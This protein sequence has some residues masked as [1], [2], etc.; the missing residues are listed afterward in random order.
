MKIRKILLVL[1]LLWFGLCLNPVYPAGFSDPIVEQMT[2]LFFEKYSSQHD[3]KHDEILRGL[4]L[5]PSD[6]LEEYEDDDEMG[7]FYI[8]MALRKKQPVWMPFLYPSLVTAYQLKNGSE[9]EMTDWELDDIFD[10]FIE[11]TNNFREAVSYLDCY[12]ELDEKKKTFITSLLFCELDF[13]KDF[14]PGEGRHFFK[15]KFKAYL[16]FVELYPDHLRYENFK[17]F[18]D[19]IPNEMV[20]PWAECWDDLEKS[21]PE[22]MCCMGLCDDPAQWSVVAGGQAQEEEHPALKKIRSRR[23]K[24]VKVFAGR[25]DNRYWLTTKTLAPGET[26]DDHIEEPCLE[27]LDQATGAHLKTR[28]VSL[29]DCGVFTTD[30]LP[31]LKFGRIPEGKELLEGIT[32]FRVVVHL[33]VMPATG[34]FANIVLKPG[35]C[36][37]EG[38][39]TIQ[40]GFSGFHYPGFNLHCADSSSGK[41][42][43]PFIYDPVCQYPNLLLYHGQGTVPYGFD[44]VSGRHQPGGF[45][46]VSVIRQVNEKEGNQGDN[47]CE[48][49]LTI[50]RLYISEVDIAQSLH[51]VSPENLPCQITGVAW[52]APEKAGEL[53]AVHQSQLAPATAEEADQFILLDV[54]QLSVHA[55]LLHGLFAR[56]GIIDYCPDQPDQLL[57]SVLTII[58]PYPDIKVTDDDDDDV[59]FQDIL[60]PI[61]DCLQMRDFEAKVDWRGILQALQDEEFIAFPPSED[62]NKVL[63]KLDYL[64]ERER[65]MERPDYAKLEWI[66]MEFESYIRM[67]AMDTN[68]QLNGDCELFRTV[69]IKKKRSK[70]VQDALESAFVACRMDLISEEHQGRLE[71]LDCERAIYDASQELQQIH[72]AFNRWKLQRMTD[73]ALSRTQCTCGSAGTLYFKARSVLDDPA[74]VLKEFQ[75]YLIKKV[76][77]TDQDLED[78]KNDIE[79]AAIDVA[80]D[81]LSRKDLRLLTEDQR[82]KIQAELEAEAPNKSAVLERM[83]EYLGA[84][85]YEGMG[86]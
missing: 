65:A 8:S 44:I 45:S 57:D 64:L 63:R 41:L 72:K 18:L 77:D 84:D 46:G 21:A 27:V 68:N 28:T 59:R 32:S 40:V 3:V 37:G 70:K 43:T 22:V 49:I 16:K 62:G 11:H 34:E 67:L 60:K 39:H 35:R 29:I 86:I 14:A 51:C 75:G 79:T 55:N 10:R 69:E 38:G 76:G 48:A 73:L 54:G 56:S 9:R 82:R 20:K 80:F 1:I 78:R 31:G 83:F 74:D 17:A 36:F 53:L 71:E 23:E 13:E 42:S 2:D 4:S 12:Q 50:H 30:E 24:E 81:I 33:Q 25:K 58:K 47:T 66:Y 5:V 19:N 61:R 52:G 6:R 26:P 15:N 7:A 85:W